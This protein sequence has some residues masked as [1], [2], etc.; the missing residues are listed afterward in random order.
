VLTD[1]RDTNA[2]SRL[3]VRTIHSFRKCGLEAQAL[4]RGIA[5]EFEGAL[6]LVDMLEVAQYPSVFIVNCAPRDGKTTNGAPFGFCHFEG[7]LI[8][9]TL[10]GYALS[11]LEKLAGKRDVRALDLVKSA[12]LLTGR[13]AELH[14][15]VQGQFRSMFFEPVA[16]AALAAGETLP[17]SPWTD[18]PGMGN[19]VLFIDSIGGRKRVNVKTSLTLGDLESQD[20]E[21]EVTVN[22]HTEQGVRFYK[23]GLKTIPQ[24]GLGLSPG[25]SGFHE[26]GM[27]LLELQRGGLEFESAAET[28][29]A[30]P[31]MEIKLK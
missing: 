22:G 21:F 30:S 9:T 8:V 17:S 11:L 25:S 16:A 26:R 13:T 29:G 12:P 5:H 2:V 1:C 23:G 15:M 31:G 7:H 4:V 6:T 3:W 20:G 14:Q 18:V 28:F 19:R 10:G 24:D 27:T